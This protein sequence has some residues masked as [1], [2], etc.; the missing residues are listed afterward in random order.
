MAP[1][2]IALKDN[3]ATVR[4][5]FCSCRDLLLRCPAETREHRRSPDSVRK[6]WS[7]IQVYSEPEYR[8]VDRLWSSALPARPRPQAARFLPSSAVEEAAGLDYRVVLP[9]LLARLDN[10]PRDD[11]PAAHYP[12]MKQKQSQQETRATVSIS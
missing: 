11:A 3:A 12:R 9:A 4:E 2:E 5:R 1:G 10:A 8:T 7:Q 6:G